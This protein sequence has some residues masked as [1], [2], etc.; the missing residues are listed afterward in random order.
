MRQA[1]LASRCREHLGHS[2]GL[3]HHAKKCGRSSPPAK[4]ARWRPETLS[5]EMPYCLH[6]SFQLERMLP[7]PGTGHEF[8]DRFPF[9][10]DLAL[11]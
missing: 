3:K 11:A 4:D 8:L 6:G 10:F 7:A 9:D 2:D 5:L 1:E